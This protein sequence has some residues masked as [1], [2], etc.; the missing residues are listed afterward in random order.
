M[1]FNDGRIRITNIREEDNFNL[2]DYIEYPIHNNKSG[3]VKMFRFSQ[4]NHILY[5]YGDD[6]NIFSFMFRCDYSVVEKNMI[7]AS[8]LSELPTLFVSKILPKVL[9]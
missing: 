9:R 6:G 3:R 2:S 1:G 4:D 8:E 5:T 7:S